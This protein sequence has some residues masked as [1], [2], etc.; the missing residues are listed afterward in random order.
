MNRL[1]KSIRTNTEKPVIWELKEILDVVELFDGALDDGSEV[2]YSILGEE[3]AR[4]VKSMFQV[5]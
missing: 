1:D 3:K 4:S 5:K 2:Y